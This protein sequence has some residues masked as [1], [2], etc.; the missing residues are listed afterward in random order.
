MKSSLYHKKSPIKDLQEDAFVLHPVYKLAGVFDGVT[1]LNSYKNK[2]QENGAHIAS[3]LFSRYFLYEYNP[4]ITLKEGILSANKKLKEEMQ[5]EA[6]DLNDKSYLW[7]TCAAIILFEEE[8]VHYAQAGD[9]MILA[10]MH[11]GKIKEVT[12]N[13]VRGISKRAKAKRETER[14]AGKDIYTEEFYSSN[15][16]ASKAYNRK[17]ANTEQGYSVCNG[18]EA[19]ENFI[20]TGFLNKDEI[21]S[22]L[23]LSDGLF[24]PEKDMAYI[25]EEALKNGLSLL[26]EKIKRTEQKMGLRPDDRTAILLR[27]M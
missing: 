20:Q 7:S 14:K 19:L 21:K 16:L 27:L 9:C 15:F 26:A 1:P 3:H 6:I 24:F 10:E 12:K 4:E 11:D 8:K 13:S 23:L 5:K 17:M 2:Y 25:M 22:I 18:E